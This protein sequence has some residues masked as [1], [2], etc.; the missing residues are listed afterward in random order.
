VIDAKDQGDCGISY[1]FAVVGA[2]ESHLMIAKNQSQKPFSEQHVLNCL[3]E[4]LQGPK[5][6][7]ESGTEIEVL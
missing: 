7:C 4:T 3:S 6:K 2:I 5:K 1:I